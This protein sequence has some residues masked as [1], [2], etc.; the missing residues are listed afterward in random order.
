MDSSQSDWHD[1]FVPPTQT[2]QLVMMSK[3]DYWWF[4]VFEWSMETK[5]P[6]QIYVKHVFPEQHVPAT[7]VK[8]SLT[9]YIRKLKIKIK[10]LPGEKYSVF[11]KI[12]KGMI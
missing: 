2:E 3:I 5:V 12:E 9:D 1:D 10:V 11:A 4:I 7:W 6:F 8:G